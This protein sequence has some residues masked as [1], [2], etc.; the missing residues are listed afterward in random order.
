MTPDFIDGET[1]SVFDNNTNTD[2]KA[3]LR[4]SKIVMV[5]APD[6]TQ[7]VYFEGTPPHNPFYTQRMGKH[8]WLPNGNLLITESESGR[9]FEVNKQG[10]IIWQYFN[11]IDEGIVGNVT[12]VSRLPVE[13]NNLFLNDELTG[14]KSSNGQ[15]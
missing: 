8:Q 1:F 12:E 6:N 5:T 9:G 2:T 14:S 10:D 13:Y 3:E 4:H 7:T 15:N 11:Y